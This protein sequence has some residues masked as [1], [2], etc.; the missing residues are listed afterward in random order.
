MAGY[1]KAPAVKA[2]EEGPTYQDA[3]SVL[4][5][6]VVKELTVLL[7][8][9][10]Y[11]ERSRAKISVTYFPQMSMKDLERCLGCVD[12]THFSRHSHIV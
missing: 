10:P 1:W 5:D 4:V 8:K 9:R 3:S 7:N 11:P 12:C 6:D 2:S